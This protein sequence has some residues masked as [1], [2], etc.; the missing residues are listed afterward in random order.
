VK[1]SDEAADKEAANTTAAVSIEP[2]TETTDVVTEVDSSSSTTTSAIEQ[3]ASSSTPSSTVDVLDEMVV[4]ESSGNA[5]GGEAA[6]GEVA[7]VDMMD[8]DTTVTM[9]SSEDVLNAINTAVLNETND[10]ST[11]TSSLIEGEAME[12]VEMSG[13]SGTT[14]VFEVMT[15]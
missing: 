6:A 15:L 2:I 11:S 9:T 8:I 14:G 7:P 5:P 3:P 10:L 13:M 4:V 12:I 1:R